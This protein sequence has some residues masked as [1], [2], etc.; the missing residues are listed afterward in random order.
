MLNDWGRGWDLRLDADDRY[1][2]ELMAFYFGFG[3]GEGVMTAR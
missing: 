1:E 3:E 2:Y